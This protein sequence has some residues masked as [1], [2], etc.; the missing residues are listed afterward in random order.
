MLA[1][2]TL[3]FLAGGGAYAAYYEAV[4]SKIQETDNAYVGGNL[5]NLSSQV[6]GNVTDIRADE[7][8]MVQAGAPLVTLDSADADVAL[9]IGQV[10]QLFLEG[11]FEYLPLFFDHEDFV[12]TLGEVVHAVRLQRPG[13]A[14]LV[15][16]DADV[17]RRLFVDAEI[18]QR[19]AR[20]EVGLAG[21]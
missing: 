6:T 17:G 18:G 4:L 13:H 9:A 20:I 16:A 3:F 8:Q 5:V 19:L 21:R 12:E 2:I 10:V 14:D 1:A 15:Q 11:V 7:T